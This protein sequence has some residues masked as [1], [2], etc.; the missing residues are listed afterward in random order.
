MTAPTLG[1]D[2]VRRLLGE[3][4]AVVD[5]IDAI[6]AAAPDERARDFAAH[7]ARLAHRD[8]NLLLGVVARADADMF[9]RNLQPL[10]ALTVPLGDAPESVR[11]AADAV[12][13]R[14][15]ALARDLRLTFDPLLTP[16]MQLPQPVLASLAAALRAVGPEYA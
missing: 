14:M 6:G 15:N 8:W 11:P 1:P 9:D 10:V 3:A 12:G 13:E 16:D 5:A 2:D 7:L 4:R